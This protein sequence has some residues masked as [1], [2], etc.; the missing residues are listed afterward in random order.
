MKIV[1]LLCLS[2]LPMLGQV[3]P[4]RYIVQLS[5]DPAA[6]HCKTAAPEFGGRLAALRQNHLPMRKTLEAKGAQVL[7]ETL[8]VS[9]FIF[10]QF[11]SERAAELASISGV[12]RV[13]P[14]RL[15]QPTLD[16]A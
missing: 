3:V 16:H 7:V 11:P 10:V 13:Y 9:N 12:A 6:A 2:M 15:Y 14:V 5:R 4:D 1:V 8:A